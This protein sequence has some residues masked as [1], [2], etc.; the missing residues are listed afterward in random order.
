MQSHGDER[1]GYLQTHILRYILTC[2]SPL[3]EDFLLW[4]NYS[5]IGLLPY[6][7]LKNNNKKAVTP[8]HLCSNTWMFY[9]TE[10]SHTVICYKWIVWSAR[11]CIAGFP[12]GKKKKN[13][14]FLLQWCCSQ[15]EIYFSD[16]ANGYHISNRRGDNLLRSLLC[17]PMDISLHR[18][19]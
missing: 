9:Y 6:H 5:L 16:F 18:M 10:F 12:S 19:T 13:L 11:Y 2:S 7:I 4:Q 17:I 1:H 15:S 3:I 8:Q 14:N